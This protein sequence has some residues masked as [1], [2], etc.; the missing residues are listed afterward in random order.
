M[1][2][3]K[4]YLKLSFYVVHVSCS[5]ADQEVINIQSTVY[6]AI[7]VFHNIIKSYIE[8]RDRQ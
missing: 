8:Q 4:V 7:N 2:L 5:L 1:E 6:S 3:I